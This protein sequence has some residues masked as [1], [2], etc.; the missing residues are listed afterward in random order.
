MTESPLIY[1]EVWEYEQDDAASVTVCRYLGSSAH[2][3]VPRMIDGLPTTSIM[4]AA[5][6]GCQSLESVIIPDTVRY[7]G[8]CAFQDCHKLSSVGMSEGLTYLGVSAFAGCGSLRYIELPDTLELISSDLFSNCI[9]LESVKLPKNLTFIGDGAFS[10]C[11]SLCDINF[12][13]TLEY[14]GAEAFGLSDLR[15][16]RFGCNL[17]V[18]DDEAFNLCDSLREIT[19]PESLKTLGD[20]AFSGCSGLLHAF[21]PSTLTEIGEN[22]FKDCPC[23]TISSPPGSYALT[24]ADQNG[25]SSCPMAQNADLDLPFSWSYDILSDGTLEIAKY[26]GTGRIAAIPPWIRGK[27]VSSIGQY[28]F[29]GWSPNIEECKGLTVFI[30]ASVKNISSIAFDGCSY[31]EGFEVEPESKW[32]HSQDGILYDAAMQTLVRFPTCSLPTRTHI[33]KSVKHIGPF[34]FS[35]SPITSFTRSALAVPVT[36]PER[37]CR[38]D[39]IAPPELK[40]IGD[41]A[42]WNCSCL[43]H[44]SMPDTVDSLGT[45]AFYGC[46]QLMG[47]LLSKNI[48][49]IKG[50]TFS[51]CASLSNLILP[52]NVEYVDRNAIFLCENLSQ[53]IVMGIDTEIHKDALPDER[54]ICITAPVGSKAQEYALSADLPF[55]ELEK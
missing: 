9:A 6:A 15:H 7:I 8:A 1:K 54:V 5:F 49:A 27:R 26:N 51:G 10:C 30:P 17:S 25:I 29:E 41:S 53:L 52:Q 18:I 28:V 3:V 36:Y 14:I 34:A 21:I 46:T 20:D 33:P 55:E 43:R 19:L 48:P 2:V 47:V 50:W 37:R 42:F 16:I 31:I 24:Y 11:F 22:A 45:A 44:I 35:G 39:V 4:S 13:D 32:Y 40:T 23:L 38:R 12:P